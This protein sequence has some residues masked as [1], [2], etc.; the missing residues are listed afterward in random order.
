MSASSAAAADGVGVAAADPPADAGSVF[1]SREKTDILGNIQKLKAQAALLRDQKKSV[2]K[3]LKNEE[4]RRKR[5]R[6]RAR[7]LTDTD[8]LA[9]LKMREAAAKSAEDA[10]AP[11]S[12]SSAASSGAGEAEAG[13]AGHVTS[14]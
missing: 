7:Q 11:S 9:L 10:I 2:S 14:D 8:L 13:V 12:S 4:K 1:D 5:L 6:E 3:Q